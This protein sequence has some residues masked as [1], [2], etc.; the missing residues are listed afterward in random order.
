MASRRGTHLSFPVKTSA[1]YVELG[2][3][4]A[5]AGRDTTKRATRE[6]RRMMASR[7]FEKRWRSCVARNANGRNRGRSTRIGSDL[8]E[9][10]EKLTS[11]MRRRQEKRER[12][13]KEREKEKRRES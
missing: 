11:V 8:R 9:R 13:R 1:M 12:R 10:L 4:V 6:A 5:L 3:P 2:I 7:R